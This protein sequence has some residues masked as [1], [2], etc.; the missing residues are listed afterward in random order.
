MRL[1]V[2]PARGGSARIPR[3]NLKTFR[4]RPL[5]AWSIETATR[6]GLFDHVMVSTEDDEIASVAAQWGATAPFRRPHD[7]ASD[8]A[9]TVDVIA[10]AV[11]WALDRDWAVSAVCC[12]YATPFIRT[13]DLAQGLRVLETDRCSYVFAA[14]PFTEPLFRAFQEREHGGVEMLFPDYYASRSQDLPVVL[15][16]AAQFYWG[17]TSAW[18]QGRQIFDRDSRIVIVPR[19][20]AQDIDTHDDWGRAEAMFDRLREHGDGVGTV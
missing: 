2:I 19:W 4:G 20:R 9:D 1:A 18:L 17:T 13:D 15:H 11:R 3:K 5:M 14:T 10:H 6:S 7:L 12:I 8:H 16:D